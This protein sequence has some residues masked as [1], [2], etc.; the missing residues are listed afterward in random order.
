MDNKKREMTNKLYKINN[1]WYYNCHNKELSVFEVDK[2]IKKFKI[3]NK[4]VVEILTTFEINNNQWYLN[5]ITD[6]LYIKICLIR[7][8]F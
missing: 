3:Y 1:K 7:Y 4:N 8:G 6:K 2:I 5:I